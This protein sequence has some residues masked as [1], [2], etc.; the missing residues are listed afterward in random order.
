MDRESQSSRPAHKAEHAEATNRSSTMDLSPCDRCAKQTGE[1]AER[2]ESAVTSPVPLRHIGRDETT[3][4]GN[5]GDTE[6]E[7]EIRRVEQTHVDTPPH[8][9]RTTE[10]LIQALFSADQQCRPVVVIKPKMKRYR[11]WAAA[12]ETRRK[13]RTRPDACA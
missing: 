6:K 13:I 1:D 8:G 3:Q 12:T 5:D 11:P 2:K 7:N 4:R 9:R 10:C